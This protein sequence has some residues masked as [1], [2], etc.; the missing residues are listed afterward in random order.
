MGRRSSLVK[1]ATLVAVTGLL[2]AAC[3]KSSTSGDTTTTAASGGG[4]AAARGGDGALDIATIISETG[5]LGAYGPGVLAA[6]K[7]A[8]DDINGAGGV[9][10]QPV[11]L[12]ANQ[13][14]AST[15]EQAGTAADQVVNGTKADAVIGALGSGASAAIIEK[16]ASAGL[17][18]C[19]PSNTAAS[20]TQKNDYGGHYF[21]TAPSDDL[22]A[23]VLADRIIQDGRKKIAIIA[24]NDDYGTGFASALKTDLENGGATVTQSVSYDSKSP[25]VKAQVQQALNSNPDTIAMISFTDDGAKVL[26]ALIENGWSPGQKPVYGTDGIQGDTVDAQGQLKPKSVGAQV[27]PNDPKALDGLMGSAPAFS[28]APEFKARFEAVKPPTAQSVFTGQAYDCVTIIALAAEQAKSDK[29]S[30]IIANIQKVTNDGE[31]CTS[32][33]ACKKLIDAGNDIA[34]VGAVGPINLDANGDPTVGEYEIWELQDGRL[35]TLENV[36]Q[37]RN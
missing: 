32:F 31:Q 14:D 13:D 28:M 34:Y 24:R 19:S 37:T 18:Q 26:S 12:E 21:R 35:K 7:L 16:L 25:D 17:V 11:T 23:P 6:I 30:D 8:V 3:S 1:L 4:Q 36:K 5:D 22:Q 27:N 10:G 20:L 2:V 15:A 9:L 33:A 29:T